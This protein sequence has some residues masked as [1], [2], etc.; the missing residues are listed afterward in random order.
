[1]RLVI[2]VVAGRAG[3]TLVYSSLF[4][5]FPPRVQSRI[6][7]RVSPNRASM[8]DSAP[9]CPVTRPGN[10]FPKNG[11]PHDCDPHAAERSAGGHPGAQIAACWTPP[12]PKRRGA[13]GRC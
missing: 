6:T 2:G 3:V 9:P 13:R 1:R 10:V 7:S 8:P 12:E 5:P 11:T 4:A